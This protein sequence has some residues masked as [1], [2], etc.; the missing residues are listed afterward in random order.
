ML[1]GDQ[2]KEQKVHSYVVVD[3]MKCLEKNRDLRPKYQGCVGNIDE[4]A[5]DPPCAKDTDEVTINQWLEKKKIFGIALNKKANFATKHSGVH[6]EED[7]EIRQS[8]FWL[9][10]IPMYSKFTDSG[11]RYRKNEYHISK[12]WMP[13]APTIIKEFYDIRKFN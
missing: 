13:L 2:V 5:I 8:E 10:S 6:E 12:S 3:F 11:Y 1:E 4:C 7:E 9:D